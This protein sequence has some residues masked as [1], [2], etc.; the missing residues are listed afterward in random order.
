MGSKI[1]IYS[2]SR[3]NTCRKAL[4]WMSQNDIG[5]NLFDI[6]QTPPSKEIISI[7][8]E[9]FENR[10]SLFNTSG[11]R[12]R[13]IGAKV[14]NSMSK[15]EAIQLLSEDGKLIKRPFLVFQDG[16]KI[17][18]GFNLDRWKEALLK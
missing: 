7:A 11:V 1:E 4:K 9:K 3:C 13:E 10:K 5:Y 18:A 2:Y 15:T 17:L 14:I 12:Y 6:I 8:F 16:S